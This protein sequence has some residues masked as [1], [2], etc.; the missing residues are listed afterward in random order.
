[1]K[2][3][4]PTL[5]FLLC[6]VALTL[7]SSCSSPKQ[8]FYFQ[9]GPA[10]PKVVKQPPTA[11]PVYTASN[12][13]SLADLPRKPLA[14]LTETENGEKAPVKALSKKEVR[15]LVRKTIKALQDSTNTRNKDRGRVSASINKDRLA[16]LET[17]AQELKNS[18][19][20]Q[21]SDNKVTVDVQ[22]PVSDLSQT[23][24]ILVGVAALLVLII[25]LSLP[26]IG[27]IL[28]AILGIAL[29]AAAVAILLGYIEIN[30]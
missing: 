14:A 7:A 24:L 25:L 3:T 16:R 4:R 23:E 1:M 17:Q 11:E 29:I 28:G 22:K 20:V 18:V 19:R 12:E 13:L 26:V 27:N 21:N 8:V 10:T 6:F 5:Y 15:Q 9:P 2:N 30:I